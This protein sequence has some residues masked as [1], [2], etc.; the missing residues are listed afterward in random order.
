MP[1]YEYACQDCGRQFEELQGIHD[2]PLKKCKFCGGKAERLISQTSFALKGSG[3][4][5]DGYS[6]PKPAPDAK[7]TKPEPKAGEKSPPAKES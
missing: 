4:Y 3:W 7:T 5:K 6:N 2:K 1:V